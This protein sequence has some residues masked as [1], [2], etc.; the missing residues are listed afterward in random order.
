MKR[1]RAALKS[2]MP[3]L[4]G[5]FVALLVFGVFNS[6]FLSGRIAYGLSSVD[7]NTAESK[8]KQSEAIAP[9]KETEPQITINKIQVNAPV[10][11]QQV[12]EDEA[13]FQRLLQNGTVHYPNTTRPG[14]GG[15][16]VIFGHSSGQWWAPGNYKFVFTLLEKLE[17]ND[18]IFIDYDGVRYMYLVSKKYIVTP[19]DVSVL[20]P[21][22]DS[23][24]TLITCT[25]VGSNAKRLI[26]E[27]T[28]V[29]PVPKERDQK[30]IKSN[31]DSLQS[32][33]QKLPGGSP[34]TWETIQRALN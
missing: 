13:E 7:K 6:Q 28:Q 26:I 4:V 20:Q 8:D 34:S 24:L 30:L 16:T 23:R 10:I 32:A 27:A 3:P 31:L 14:E 12:A 29:I 18:K 11:F 33:P 19:D 9:D 21:T 25:P 5:L 2:F 1:R 15:N 22:T 17:P